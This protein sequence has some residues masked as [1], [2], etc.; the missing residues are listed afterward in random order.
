MWGLLIIILTRID[1]IH[2]SGLSSGV[3]QASSPW[4]TRRHWKCV[5][6]C[7]ILFG[8][9]DE[10]WLIL[11]WPCTSMAIPAGIPVYLSLGSRECSTL[12]TRISPLASSARPPR[13]SSRHRKPDWEKCWHTRPWSH[14]RVLLDKKSI[15]PRAWRQSANYGFPTFRDKQNFRRLLLSCRMQLM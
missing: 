9:L 12:L 6:Y 15:L 2:L 4:K 5:Q 13:S 14:C 3:L 8:E 11:Q 10:L 7:G 1:F